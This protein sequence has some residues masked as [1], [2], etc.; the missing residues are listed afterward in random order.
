[1]W[2]HNKTFTE[3][4][5]IT[6]GMACSKGGYETSYSSGEIDTSASITIWDDNDT[7]VVYPNMTKFYANYTKGD[8]ASI[9]GTVSQ[10]CEFSFNKTG[11]AWDLYAPVNMSFNN[12]TLQYEIIADGGYIKNA[13]ETH[14]GGMPVGTYGYNISCYDD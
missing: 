3:T 10:Y 11:L 12:N 9:N 8:G 1:L 6:Y 7:K 2:E 5:N 13:S 4:G 14:I